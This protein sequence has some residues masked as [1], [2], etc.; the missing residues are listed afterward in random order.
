MPGVGK[1]LTVN[2]VID[3][4]KANKKYRNLFTF[5]YFNAMNFPIPTNIYRSMLLKIFG[6]NTKT[7][8]LSKLSTFYNKHR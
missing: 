5:N 7:S 4:L 6:E 1:T 2:S 3:K 8:I